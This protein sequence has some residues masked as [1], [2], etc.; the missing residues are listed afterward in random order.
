MVP[1]VIWQDNTGE[2][3]EASLDDFGNQT[4]SL[5]D[6]EKVI[7]NRLRDK[8]I[9]KRYGK[10]SDLLKLNLYQGRPNG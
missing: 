7:Q 4:F 2:Q 8:K 5:G 1:T 9:T 6:S 10:L 3:V